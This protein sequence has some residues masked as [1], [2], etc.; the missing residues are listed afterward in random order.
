MKMAK[1]R[2]LLTI[3]YL[4]PWSAAKIEAVIL[5]ALGFVLGI[6]LGILW[7]LGYVDLSNLPFS[8]LIMAILLPFFY[9]IFYGILGLVLGALGA[10]LYNVFAK[11][12]GG[13]KIEFEK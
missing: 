8:P 9:G 2:N 7:S 4:S 11:W 5:A 1:N 13:I 3:K 12:L 6:I 10:W